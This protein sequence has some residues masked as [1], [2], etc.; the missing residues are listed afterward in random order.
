MISIAGVDPGTNRLG[1]AL[2]Q[3]ENRLPR[4]IAAE[5]ITIPKRSHAPEELALLERALAQRLER[6]QPDGL[7]V[8]KLFFAK[9]TK[10][11]LS[12]A[13]ARGIILLTAR[14]RIRS[15]WEYT[16][17]EIK[18]SVTG[19]GRADKN[20]M[21]RMIRLILPGAQLPPGD[22][23]VDAIAIALAAIYINRIT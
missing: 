7:A 17:L 6:D 4:L 8:E 13:Q 14:Q 22:D 5:T 12:V 3:V 19:F 15:I 11:A 20:Q 10:T 21:R 2:V 16:P 9:N 18:M 23:A 1:Y